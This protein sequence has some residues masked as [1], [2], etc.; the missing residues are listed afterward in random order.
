MQLPYHAMQQLNQAKQDYQGQ[1]YLAATGTLDKILNTYPKNPGSAEAYFVRALC[2]SK[3]SNKKQ[4][5][6]DARKCIKLSPQA[7]LTSDAHATLATL[8]YESGRTREALTHFSEAFKNTRGRSNEDVVI[9]RYALCLQREGQWKEARIQFEQ[10]YQHYPNTTTAQHARR[11]F[12][13]PHDYYSIQCGA[14]RD[15]GAASM[16]SRELRRSGLSSRV[17]RRRRSGEQLYTVY[18]GK[19]SRYGQAKDALP[20]VRRQ[21]RDAFVMPQ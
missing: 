13:W 16:Q 1:D 11:L 9:Y 3:L 14:F 19:Y 15:K 8:L 12:D 6:S 10:I 18:V 5:E 7:D 2:H 21:I 20:S 4:A 17:E